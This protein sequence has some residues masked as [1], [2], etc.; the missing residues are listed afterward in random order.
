MSPPMPCV[1][2]SIRKHSAKA[3]HL[4]GSRALGLRSLGNEQM[5]ICRN[6]LDV[7][8]CRLRNWILLSLSL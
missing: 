5:A 3:L 7:S 2:L 4:K 8:G 6:V 1:A